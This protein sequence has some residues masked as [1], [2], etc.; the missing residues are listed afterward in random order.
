MPILYASVA[1]LV[2]NPV[3]FFPDYSITVHPKEIAELK[4]EDIAGVETYVIISIDENSGQ[5]SA[6]LQGPILIDNK[7]ALFEFQIFNY[8]IIDAGRKT[9]APAWYTQTQFEIF[10]YSGENPDRYFS[11]PGVICNLFDFYRTIF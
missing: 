6:N 8:S 10:F 5:I 1:F 4:V 3:L 7:I 2:A 11:V 9:P